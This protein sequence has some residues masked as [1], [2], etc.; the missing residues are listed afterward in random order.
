MRCPRA[1]LAVPHV[2]RGR[3]L[4]PD[5]GGEAVEYDGFTTPRLDLDELVWSRAEPGP[6]FDL[7]VAEII[8]F[9]VA[10]GE[11][12]DLDANRTCNTRSSTASR[13]ASL[14]ERV[15]AQAYRGLPGVFDRVVVVVPGGPRGRAGRARRLGNGRG[16]ERARPAHPRLPPRLI[17]VLAGNTPGVTGISIARGAL[18]KGVH[19]LKLPSNDLFTGTAILRTMAELD[20]D[21]P[22][23]RSFSCVYWRGGDAAVEGALF[24]A[25]YF[26]RLVGV[27]RRRRDPQRAQVHRARVR[28]RV[29]RSQGL[30]LAARPRGARIRGRD[31]RVRGRGRDRRAACSTRR[32]ARQAASS[33]PK[34]IVMRSRL[35]R[36][37][38]R[39]SSPSSAPT[40]MPSSRTLAPPT[41]ARKSTCSGR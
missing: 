38:S 30:D 7:P 33:T 3:L 28:S 4:E 20:P 37:S 1:Q 15:L 16:S 10:V 26:D 2:V 25:Q 8:D 24:R 27:G 22:V 31:G 14:G 18:T 19:L 39:P 23:T 11:R 41:S 29:V 34:A 12:L 13:S 17:H 9:L 36:D 32:C 6:A 40:P 21:H 5:G 35:V